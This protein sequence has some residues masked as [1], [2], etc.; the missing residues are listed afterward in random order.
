MRVHA[1]S[2][3]PSLALLLHRDL[4]ATIPLTMAVMAYDASDIRHYDDS[5]SRRLDQP[6]H[7]LG[8]RHNASANRLSRPAFCL[9]ARPGRRLELDTNIAIAGVQQ[10]DG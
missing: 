7:R 8:L 5:R 9:S 6:P 10:F 1:G 3:A 2:E 4:D